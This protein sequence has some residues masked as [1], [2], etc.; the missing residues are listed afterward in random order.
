MST[1]QS[2]FGRCPLCPDATAELVKLCKTELLGVLDH[3]QRHARNVHAD[4]TSSGLV[5]H[6][7]RFS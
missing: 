6:I 2:L 5:R 4:C 7:D 1:A 3:H